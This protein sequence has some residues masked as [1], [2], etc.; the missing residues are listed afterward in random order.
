M[1]KFGTFC[2]ATS[3]VTPLMALVAHAQFAAPNPEELKMTA[4]PKAPGA[5]AVYLVREEMSDDP[6]HF[7]TVYARI[8]V[9]T[10]RG[11]EA[12]TVHITYN[13]SFVFN[14]S[15]SN[16]SRMGAGTSN[17][18]EAP[19]VNHAGE[20]QPFVTDSFQVK[21]DVS[22]IEGRTIH[23]DGTVVPLTGNPSDLLVV[24]R[25]RNQMDDMAFTLPAV[26]VGSVLEYK[27]Q[28]R[29]DRFEEAP[30]WQIQQLYFVHRAH[31]SFTPA[32]KFNPMRNKGGAAGVEDSA[33]LDGHGEIITDIQYA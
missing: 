27:Y 5:D 29:Y 20:D 15:G 9:L 8:K 2:L 26:E 18:W 3:L 28:I 30:D 31:Y 7:R 21:T 25:G 24:K 6:H 1:R 12:A 23:A 16:S 13:R 10:E 19:N 22:A 14:A 33:L 32:E 11:K 17:H 4:D